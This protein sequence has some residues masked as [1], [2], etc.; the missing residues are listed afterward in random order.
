MINIVSKILIKEASCLSQPPKVTFQNHAVIGTWSLIVR[1][2]SCHL[3]PFPNK[4]SDFPKD[5]RLSGR[6][7]LVSATA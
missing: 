5:S 1:L 4:I 7:I 6:F 2:S 3:S